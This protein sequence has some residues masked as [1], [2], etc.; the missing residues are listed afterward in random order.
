MLWL[1]LCVSIML[2]WGIDVVIIP[3]LEVKRKT[4]GD[5]GI[6]FWPIDTTA[7]GY[8]L[9]LQHCLLQQMY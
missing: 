5:G 4:E 8:V 2:F 6:R 9:S 3:L 7:A 1:M